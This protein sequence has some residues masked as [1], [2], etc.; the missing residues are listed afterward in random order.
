MRPS[1]GPR[2]ARGYFFGTLVYLPVLLG[3]LVVDQ[4]VR[5]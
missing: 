1:S 4:F 5:L 3:V 2:W